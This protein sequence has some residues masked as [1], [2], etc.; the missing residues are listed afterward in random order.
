MML[1]NS[2]DADK[3]AEICH[4]T[5]PSLS[6][7][8]FVYLACMLLTLVELLLNFS[9]LILKWRLAH[10][11]FRGLGREVRNNTVKSEGPMSRT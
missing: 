9:F 3:K 1:E 10:L 5:N 2:Y 6:P 8:L 11:N 7:H 4:F